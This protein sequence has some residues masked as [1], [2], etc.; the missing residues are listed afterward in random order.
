MQTIAGII[1]QLIIVNLKIWHS[2]DC[3]KDKLLSDCERLKAADRVVEANFQRNNLID[4]L[5]EMFSQSIKN[6]N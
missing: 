6:G 3:Q 4:E 5:D 2:I 1:D